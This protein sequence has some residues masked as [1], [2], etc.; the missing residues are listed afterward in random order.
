MSTRVLLAA[1]VAA[2]LLP[3]TSLAQT[4]APPTDP[5][6]EE[7]T[8]R[9][10]IPM[11]QKGDAAETV[12]PATRPA[13][14]AKVAVFR[15]SNT[16]L[17]RPADFTLN[18]FG[19]LPE[20]SPALSQ[21]TVQL[22]RAA[23]DP[24]IAGVML[25][26]NAFDLSLA[27][28][29]ELGSLLRNLRENKKRV[30]V[31][32]PEFDT[33]TY[34]VASHADTVIM[35]E[36]G[37]VLMPGVSMGLM[38]WKGMLDNVKLK[39]DMVQV[40]KFKGAEEPYTRT[41]ASPELKAQINELADALYGQIV[42]TIARNR[43]MEEKEAKA[44]IDEAWFTGKRAKELGLIDQ[45]LAP[46]KV[47]TWLD[48]QFA[49]GVERV[50]DYGERKKK[51]ID[52]N[53]PFAFFQLM[54]APK[55]STRTNQ[56]AIAVIYA[57]GAIM[58][59]VPDGADD[60]GVVT[61]RRIREA[62]DR[63]LK[64]DLVKA[65]VLRVDSPGGSASASDDIW[66]ALREADL[67]KPVTVSMG[68]VAASG[69]YYIACAGRSITADQATITGSIGVVGGKIVT[70][71]LTDWAG[72]NIEPIERGKRA[73]I[74]STDRPFTEDER[75]F[76]RQQMTEVYDLFTK[77]VKEGRG[78]KIA[79]I[80]DVAQGRIFDGNA[81]RKVG[82]V[83]NLGTLQDTITAAAKSA[84]IE[85]NY[86]VLVYPEQRTFADVLREG[87][88]VDASLPLELSAAT[89]VLP[90]AYRKE[91]VKA[92]QMLSTLQEE[93]VMVAFPAGIIE[94]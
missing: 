51:P 52:M 9:I 71:D 22:N 27:Q 91:A 17:E 82:L 32:S 64:D 47:N 19:G 5:T 13:A 77:R 35:P 68:R 65:I 23:K 28:A 62:L 74:L 20:K 58:P 34:L 75:A 31:Y 93:K 6:T 44:V 43:G 42:S 25:E 61:P 89:K 55:A 4:G 90:P 16:L 79:K 24:S 14:K 69:G 18:L 30:A 21:L 11:T 26:L 94:R 76:V 48:G 70:R 63:A 87:F 67:K 1:A 3:L 73:G 56:P 40:G 57:D 45:L 41:E 60:T 92:I 81:A 80:E 78:N 83:D 10:V 36:N 29:Q 2:A 7:G 15:L 38:F 49:A 8:E 50:T 33:T 85:R 12:K 86:Q 37:T 66:A 46:D 53:S 84:K 59:D 88:T 54:G 72:I 39:A